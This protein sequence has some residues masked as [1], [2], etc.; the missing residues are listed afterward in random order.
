MV[1]PLRRSHA[2]FLQRQIHQR[3]T[4]KQTLDMIAV[5]AAAA[6]WLDKS[7]KKQLTR[8]SVNGKVW[9]NQILE[10]NPVPVIWVINRIAQIDPAS[11]RRFQHHFEL[12]SPPQG[13]RQALV[14]RALRDVKVSEGFA[15]RLAE[16]KGLTHAQAHGSEVCALGG[17]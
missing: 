5:P 6:E 15:A 9:V 7:L 13:A 10:T 12:K 3:R 17:G 16:R 11:R 8:A 4:Q 14:V 1:R 2:I